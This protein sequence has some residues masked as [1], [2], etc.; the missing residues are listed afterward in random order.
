ML[1]SFQND[2]NIKNNNKITGNSITFDVGVGRSFF[3]QSVFPTSQALNLLENEAE[4]DD[5]K[6]KGDNAREDLINNIN[7]D[8]DDEDV[9]EDDN[10][11]AIKNDKII[12]AE[13]EF[14]E[15][16]ETGPNNKHDNNTFN[17]TPICFNVG[18]AVR[19]NDTH[20]NKINTFNNFN[21]AKKDSNKIKLQ[22]FNKITFNRTKNQ[23]KNFIIW[24]PYNHNNKHNNYF[25]DKNFK[26]ETHKINN[27]NMKNN[28]NNNKNNNK[29][30]NTILASKSGGRYLTITLHTV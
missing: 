29:N 10:G 28:N 12:N 13:N 5:G 24:C 23:Y 17:E 4:N 21:N 8:A 9:D 30:N 18:T 1:I 3:L 27:N 22:D 7:D 20:N 14:K 25:Y 2:G 19:T 16:I 26:D 11:I 15:H 6:T